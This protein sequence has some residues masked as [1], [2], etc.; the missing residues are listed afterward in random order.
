MG[1]SIWENLAES[2][3]IAPEGFHVC[4]CA[5]VL[6]F[7]TRTLTIAFLGVFFLV[8]TKTCQ[9]QFSFPWSG[10]KKEWDYKGIIT[11]VMLEK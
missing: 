8:Y 5:G 7:V 2:M 4:Q 1:F 3:E 10:V 6:G 9:F 11:F